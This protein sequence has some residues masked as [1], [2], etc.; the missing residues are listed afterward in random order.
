M[1]PAV[2][3]LIQRRGASLPLRPLEAAAIADRSELLM[4]LMLLHFSLGWRSLYVAVP[5]AVYAA[6]PIVFIAG[7]LVMGAFLVYV[8]RSAMV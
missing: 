1:R 3:D 2:R 6:G 4:R 8:D 5:V 7:T